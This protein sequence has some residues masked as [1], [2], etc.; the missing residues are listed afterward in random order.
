MEHKTVVGIGEALF[1]VFPE[2]RKIG[3]APANFAYHCTQM[4]LEGVAVS[5]VGNDELGDEIAAIFETNGLKHHLQRHATPTGTVQV[6]LDEAGVPSYEI[7]EGVAWDNI[8]YDERLRTL[9]TKADCVCYGSL[10]QRS[11][12]S[13]AAIEQFL[14]DMR[15]DAV[16]I[17]D[18]NLRQHFYTRELIESNLKRCTVL[19]INDDEIKVVASM[20]DIEGTLEQVGRALLD[21]FGLHAVILTC[22]VDGS[23]VFTKDA[24][25]FLP[26]PRVEVADTVG[27]GDS[28]TAAFCASILKGDDIATAHRKAVD[29][30]A[31]V[32]TQTGAM[33]TLP[34]HLRN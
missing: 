10:A 11:A 1:D 18:I 3:G 14:A 15:P 22:G 29:V 30:S 9:A 28:F 12:A 20:L 27:A 16:K 4:G 31:Y 8:R 6:T 33:P 32:C 24:V 13:R 19:K 17:F 26:T 21:R 23:Y 5:S 2:G 7:K 34:D 25:S